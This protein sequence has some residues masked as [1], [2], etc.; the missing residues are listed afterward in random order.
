MRR[1]S[2]LALLLAFT[3]CQPATA[4][5][6]ATIGPH[7]DRGGIG[8]LSSAISSGGNSSAALDVDPRRSLAV[9]DGAILSSFSLTEVLDKIAAQSGGGVTSTSIFRQWWDSANPAP[10][11]GTGGT[12]CDAASNPAINHFGYQ[13]PR[14]EGKQ[15]FAANGIDST[16]AAYKAIGLFNR[17]DLAPAN[18][19]DCGEYRIAFAKTSATSIG[20]RNLLI[21]EAVLPNPHPELGLPGCGPVAQFWADLTTNASV[22]SRAGKLHDFY[23]QGLPGFEPVVH[24]DHYGA[25]AAGAGQIRSNQ[26]IT[27]DWLLREFK[28]KKCVS[29]GGVGCGVTV[30]PVTVK[31]NPFGPLF[32]P[33]STLPEAA[34][35]RTQFVAAVDG[36]AVND[37]NGFSYAPADS[38]NAA[39]SDEQSSQNNYLAQ[40]GAGSS[41]LRTAIQTRLS[42]IGSPLTPDNIVAR[43]TALSCAGCHQLSN[44]ANLGGG[45]T[46]PSSQGFTQVSEFLENGPDGQR[47]Q[48]SN[49]LTNVFLPHRK[50]VLESFLASIAPPPGDCGK[51]L[52][53]CCG[54]LVCARDADACPVICLPPPEDQ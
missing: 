13:C 24:V 9:T 29:G 3:G 16:P 46:W 38:F 50:K 35:F 54:V 30:N 51:K 26:F 21:F 36:L 42:T 33:S 19:S 49:A 10:G 39:E 48:I 37:V 44:G 15:A 41:P 20:G 17:F 34:P 14:D 12:H 18:G 32:N 40:L 2:Y 8:V 45:I 5:P 47:F 27:F 4:E 52:P 11:A 7:S 6:A 1:L 53:N 22:S 31:V 25:G 28:L 43:A 23:F